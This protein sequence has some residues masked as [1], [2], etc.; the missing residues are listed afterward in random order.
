M[1]G[2]KTP[3]QSRHA[4]V[5]EQAWLES[6]AGAPH[7]QFIK[8]CAA[9]RKSQIDFHGSLKQFVVELRA[10]KERRAQKRVQYGTYKLKQRMT[11]CNEQDASGSCNEET[12]P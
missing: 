6:F 7:R 4:P 2:P 12:E 5:L 3:C 10:E 8:S 11:F 1:I 9:G